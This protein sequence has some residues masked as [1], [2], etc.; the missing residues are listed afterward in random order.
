MNEPIRKE[1]IAKL[2]LGDI[3]KRR[4]NPYVESARIEHGRVVYIHP[5]LRFF[6]LAFTAKNGAVFRESYIPNGADKE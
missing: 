1:N 3:V 2:K 6:T 5:Q 4:P